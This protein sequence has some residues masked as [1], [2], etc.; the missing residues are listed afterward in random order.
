MTEEDKG[1][2]ETMTILVVDDDRE[3]RS[4][5]ADYLQ[6]N[7]FRVLSA[8]D[9]EAMHKLMRSSHVDF[10]ILDLTLPD[11]DGLTLCRQIRSGSTVPIIMLTARSADI[12]RILGLEMGADDYM[13]KP[14]NPRE[15]LARI[16]AV[17]RRATTV[18][19]ANGNQPAKLYSFCGWRMDLRLRELRDPMDVKVSITSAE[20]DLL[21]SFCERAGEVLS[22]E[23]LLKLTRGRNQGALDR[24]V[25]VLVS[26]LRQKIEVDP[27]DAA[28]IKTVRQNGYLFT[29]IVES[30]DLAAKL[31]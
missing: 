13:V 12:D 18:Q 21:R 15:L 11:V 19:K 20:F 5:I 27:Q 30:I 3:V 25:D 31:V 4:L 22:R 24:S 1:M 7:G 14:F 10:L 17:Q 29:P 2:I 28:F 26:R 8:A 9:A 16:N 6:A 23:V